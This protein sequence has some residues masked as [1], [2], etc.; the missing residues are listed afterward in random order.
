MWVLTRAI[1]IEAVFTDPQAYS[2]PLP[3]G[4]TLALLWAANVTGRYEIP[5]V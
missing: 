1:D 4:Y 5:A 2:A 3:A